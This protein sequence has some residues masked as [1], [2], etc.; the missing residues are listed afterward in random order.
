MSAWR[1]DEERLSDAHAL[2]LQWVMVLLEPA[3]FSMTFR[4]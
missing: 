3:R 4:R 2:G 1:A